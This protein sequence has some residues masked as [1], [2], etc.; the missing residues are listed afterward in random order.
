MC[1]ASTN[2]PANFCTLMNKILHPYLDQL[3]VVYLDDIVIFSNTSEEHVE[4]LRKVFKILRVNQLYV[5]REKCEFAQPKVHFLGHI[6]TQ[7]E[8][9][10]DEAKI[11]A[12]QEW[13]APKK[14]TELRSFLGLVNYHRTL[15]THMEALPIRLKIHSEDRQCYH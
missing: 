1:F 2:V 13:E 3:V 11:R 15:S 14:V 7:G 9:R 8:L 6:I 4:H 10:M 12:I 5:K